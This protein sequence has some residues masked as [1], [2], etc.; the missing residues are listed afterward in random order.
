MAQGLRVP[1]EM[2][3]GKPDQEMSL[4]KL[5]L[6]LGR[7]LWGMMLRDQQIALDYLES[8]PEVDPTRIGAQGMSMGSTQAWWLGAIDDRIKA[9]VGVACLTR[10]ED[11][12]CSPSTQ[13]SWN[14]LF[15]CQ[16][17]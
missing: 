6:W 1:L 10:Y 16:E 13:R 15:V 4:T 17:F 5:N 9:V 3:D 12:D 14:L 7:T 11:L 2:Q 8:R